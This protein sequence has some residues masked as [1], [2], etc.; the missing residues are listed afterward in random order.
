[1]PDGREATAGATN[2]LAPFPAGEQDTST[3]ADLVTARIAA[4][5]NTIR[6]V[7]N[8]VD[9]EDPTTADILHVLLA[10]LEKQAW[11]TA[12]ENHRTTA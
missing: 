6:T 2:A 11:M 4:T 9:A 7:R 12:A 1:M 5:A 10:N 8:P 3:T